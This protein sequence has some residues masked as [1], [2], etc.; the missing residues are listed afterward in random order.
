MVKYVDIMLTDGVR[1]TKNVCEKKD[2]DW[3]ALKLVF[4]A[5]SLQ[6]ASTI[7]IQTKRY[8]DGA[9]RLNTNYGIMSFSAR[10]HVKHLVI[11]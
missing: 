1:R 2:R 11:C 8:L 5:N 10:T 4:V 9:I 3:V 7:Q 6:I